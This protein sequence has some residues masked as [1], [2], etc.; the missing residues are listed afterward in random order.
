MVGTAIL[1]AVACG[2][3]GGTSYGQPSAYR[4]SM[5]KSYRFEP[6]VLQ[7]PAGTTVTWVNDDD[8]AH[9]VKFTKGADFQSKPLQPGDNVSYTF[10][11]P[12]EYEFECGLHPQIMKGKI[13]VQSAG[14]PGY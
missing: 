14:S 2:T 13:V 8:I 10:P 12:G 1:M 11:M 6:S 9:S 7:V 3:A 4:V 5:V